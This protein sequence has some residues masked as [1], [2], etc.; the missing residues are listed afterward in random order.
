[1]PSVQEIRTTPRYGAQDG[2]PSNSPSACP[3]LANSQATGQCNP[4][5]SMCGASFSE[6]SA[7]GASLGW[8][9]GVPRAYDAAVP[10]AITRAT[11]LPGRCCTSVSRKLDARHP[12]GVDGLP[13]Y[14]C[15]NLLA[16]CEPAD[17]AEIGTCNRHL[18]AEIAS[19]PRP[20]GTLSL[21]GTAIIVCVPMV[22]DRRTCGSGMARSITCPRAERFADSY[23][24][25]RLNTNSGRL[26]EAMPH[27]GPRGTGPA[28]GAV[29]RLNQV[30]STAGR[31]QLTIALT[32][33]R[34]ATTPF[35]C[36]CVAVGVDRATLRWC[37][38]ALE[39]GASSPVAISSQTNSQISS[40]R[41]TVDHW[42]PKRDRRT[43][44]MLEAHP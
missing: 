40:S 28:F 15:Q 9:L 43:H 16:T 17:A 34:V 22:Y 44:R 8:H 4:D 31:V 24:V 1:M 35:G 41:Q 27:R 2:R 23:H 5:G 3:R 29:R 12:S 10:P 39:L 25:S 30:R 11:A 38:F 19:R 21:G 13:G 6:L 20:G 18:A 26:T 36:A 42:L 37:P 14:Q 32:G 7:H 33:C